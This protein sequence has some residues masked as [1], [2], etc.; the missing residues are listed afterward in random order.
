[1]PA[2][3]SIL[4]AL[5]IMSE[6]VFKVP[7]KINDVNVPTDEMFGCA[8]VVRLPPIIPADIPPVTSTEPGTFKLPVVLLNVNPVLPA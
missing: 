1:M 7:P 4:P 3:I 2:D 8:V 6:F 5:V